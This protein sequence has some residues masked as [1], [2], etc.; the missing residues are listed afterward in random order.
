LRARPGHE[1]NVKKI[2]AT[3]LIGVALFAGRAVMKTYAWR[4]RRAAKKAP[5]RLRK[6]A[7]DELADVGSL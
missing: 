6:Q 5:A 3:V 7:P 1:G 4:L 2:A